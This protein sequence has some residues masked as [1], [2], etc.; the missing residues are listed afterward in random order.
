MANNRK[1]VVFPWTLEA[2]YHT[3]ALRTSKIAIKI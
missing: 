2:I 3:K 1:K